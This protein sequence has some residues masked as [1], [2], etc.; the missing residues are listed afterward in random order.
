MVEVATGVVGVLDL[1]DLR[2]MG[3]ELGLEV[4]AL[5]GLSSHQG[6]LANVGGWNSMHL[7]PL[8]CIYLC[9][10]S[11]ALDLGRHE[12]EVLLIERESLGRSV[13]AETVLGGGFVGLVKGEGL[14]SGNLH[15]VF[16]GVG[17][18]RMGV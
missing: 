12:L 2:V 15:F 6:R 4:I 13:L 1:E 16:L 8:H 5:L 11:G 17:V 10:A 14:E 9:G 3:T 18:G 7:H